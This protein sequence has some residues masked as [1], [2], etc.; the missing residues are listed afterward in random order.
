MVKLGE[1]LKMAK[2]G[3]KSQNVQNH[4]HHPKCK[5]P[6]HQT[7]MAQITKS[8]HFFE[9]NHHHHPFL[10]S[11]NHHPF[12]A[13]ITKSP[14]IFGLNHQSP[15]ILVPPPFSRLVATWPRI[16]CLG[17]QWISAHSSEIPILF[18]SSV[19][20]FV[21]FSKVDCLMFWPYLALN[22]SRSRKSVVFSVR[23]S[24]TCRLWN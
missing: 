10:E 22:E 3:E 8:P 12:L 15:Q 4:H 20:D 19:I 17:L 7:F 24:A 18:A 13:S 14:P 6:N 16:D 1:S 5:S 9:V 21:S 23:K 2:L 11:P